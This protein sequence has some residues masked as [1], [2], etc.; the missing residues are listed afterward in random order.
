MKEIHLGA[1]YH[2]H[3]FANPHLVV[4]DLKELQ[5]ISMHRSVLLK[6]MAALVSRIHGINMSHG[7]PSISLTLPPPDL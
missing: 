2:S 4:E 1:K 3:G 5:L 6:I 7:G